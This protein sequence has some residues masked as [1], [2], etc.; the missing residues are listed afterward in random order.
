[1]HTRTYTLARENKSDA[2]LLHDAIELVSNDVLL[3]AIVELLPAYS[4][5]GLKLVVSYEEEEHLSDALLTALSRDGWT[6][7]S[8]RIS[9]NGLT[10]HTLGR[11]PETGLGGALRRYSET[12]ERSADGWAYEA[13]QHGHE[14]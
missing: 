6:W 11:E 8:Q 10:L 3:P 2:Q 9:P 14:R 5:D 4:A 13:G 12:E 1:M 7:L